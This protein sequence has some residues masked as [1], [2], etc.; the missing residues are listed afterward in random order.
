MNKPLLGG[1]L[2]SHV[3]EDRVESV[4]ASI[5][6]GWRFDTNHSFADNG[7]ILVI[8]DPEISVIT[9]K[10][11]AQFMLCG[12]HI[13]ETNSSFCV[14]FVYAFNLETQRRELWGDISAICRGSPA[15]FRPWLLLGDFNQILSAS[16]HYSLS[17]STLPL[18]GMG[19]FREC[20]E[21]NELDD[22]PSRGVFYT[23]SNH[24]PDN[25]TLRKLDR[26]VAN[27]VWMSSYPDSVAIFHPPGD[28]DHSPCLVSL[29]SEEEVRK[30]SFK[31]FSFLASHSK[32][33]ALLTEAWQK[34]ICMGSRMFSLGQRLKNAKL[35]CRA[36]NREGFGNIQQRTDEAFSNL[37]EI[38]Q[39]LL[40]NP[41]HALFREEHVARKKWDFFAKAL[42]S[43]YRQKSR[44]RWLKEGD[45]NTAF[46]HKA[47]VAH[48]SRNRI[49][50]LRD[51]NDVRIDNQ[52]QVR[53]LILAYYTNL[54]GS[55]ASNISP[56]SVEDIRAIH[57]FR[58]SA[59]VGAQLT[60]I[61]S[62]DEIKSA[63]FSMPKNK[64]PGP[65]GFPVEFFREAW[66]IVGDD[67]ISAVK[68]FFCLW[69]SFEQV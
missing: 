44:I 31:Y 43:F 7:R 16:E 45:A 49:R 11:T 22:I 42:E 51:A 39:A 61:P 30:K 69:F 58:C 33:V 15:S 20:L 2:E 37:E 64:A 24:N 14:A 67:T 12:V 47:V 54:L 41:S 46:F 65:D 66:N 32:F 60:T 3:K 53:D 50:Y 26:A 21:D 6:P 25:P 56:F 34:D 68:E 52:A 10:K 18:S 27:E 19:E 62:S 59:S 8:W 48:Y 5:C 28:S 63:V 17:P 29:S 9:F 13:P 1:I 23:W 38:Q 40:T 57:P 35:S 55:E 36:L 4:L